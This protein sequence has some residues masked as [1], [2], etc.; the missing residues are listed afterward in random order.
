MLIYN[1]RDCKRVSVTDFPPINN[2]IRANE[3][4]PSIKV[5]LAFPKKN[6]P[7]APQHW[8]IDEEEVIGH[9]VSAKRRKVS[10]PSKYISVHEAH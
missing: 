6:F 10:P 7:G 4:F 2:S 8:Q 1:H 3:F 5:S 9:N